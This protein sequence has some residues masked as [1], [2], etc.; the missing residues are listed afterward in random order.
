MSL[1]HQILG[2]SE[3]LSDTEI[4]LKYR[5]LCKKYHPDIS[6]TESIDKMA[7]I[8]EAYSCLVK[9]K[10]TIENKKDE[11]VSSN[12]NNITKYK[13][14]A[15]AFYKQGIKLFNEVKDYSKTFELYHNKETME[16]FYGK[17]LKA[18]YYFNVVCVQF[19]NCEWSN[20]ALDKIRQL[21]RDRS[22]VKNI[23]NHLE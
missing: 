14:Q 23:R 3:N 15:Y 2:I 13:D 9:P 12:P 16:N 6:D 1:Y 4:K 18:L 21:N 8:N 17:V 22:F 20:D 10:T 19:E 11:A 5:A 7:L